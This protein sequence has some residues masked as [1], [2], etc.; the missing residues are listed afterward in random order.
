MTTKN[1]GLIDVRIMS[2]FVR[3]LVVNLL[4]AFVFAK[5][6]KVGLSALK[7][8]RQDEVRLTVIH[9]TDVYTLENFPSLCNLIREAK[10]R[11]PNTFSV[12][13]GDFLAPY[14][15]S[16]IDEGRGMMRCVAEAGIDF[17]SWGNH[18]ADVDHRVTCSHVRNFPGIWLNS[19]MVDHEAMEAQKQYFRFDAKSPDKAQSKRIGLC[20]V[21]T[22]SAQ[23][24]KP[25]AFGGATI[26]DPWKALEKCAHEI[27]VDC[28]LVI[29]FEHLYEPD[30]ERTCSEFDF[31]VVF[32]GH[33]H[34]RVDRMISGTRLL[35]PGSDSVYA[36]VCE[37]SW[38]EKDEVVVE[39][40]FVKV[41][42]WP[43]DPKIQAIVDESY[44]V[45][46]PLCN[47]QLL[48]TKM[49]AKLSSKGAREKVTSMAV[50]LCSLLREALDVDCVLLMGGNIRGGRDYDDDDS[51]F[52]LESLMAEIEEDQAVGIVN[53]P[54]SLISDAVKFSHSNGPIPGWFQ[55]DDQVEED[56]ATGEILS[57][58][59][60]P[61]DPDKMYAVATKLPD[62]TN[63]QSPQL[64]RYFSNEASKERRDAQTRNIHAIILEHCATSVARELL[65]RLSEDDD[66][67]TKKGLFLDATSSRV[68]KALHTTL[69]MSVDERELSF[70]KLVRE[71]LLES[72]SSPR[73]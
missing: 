27:L 5:I 24:Y 64:T 18:D 62:L 37:I 54:G 3:C 56:L 39:A 4:L 16:Q 65:S 72:I 51:F 69:G 48:S 42:Q 19:N 68:Q 47:T 43:A 49:P 15:L 38:N 44:D 1:R 8:I 52:S 58:R 11:N 17:L 30:D 13:S 46:K 63:G 73:V 36:T 70:A 35:K 53:I 61:I 57:I 34:H 6:E 22:D 50:F 59:G 31:P 28:D 26:S 25:G 67:E 21:L 7:E 60:K 14:L 12:L 41:D 10:A 9:I 55:Y 66:N 2:F 71:Q 33:D 20:A 32:S 45:L 29:P 23:L 40:R